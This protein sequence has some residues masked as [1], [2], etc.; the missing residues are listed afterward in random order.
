M[1]MAIIK[2]LLGLF[3][4]VGA[5]SFAPMQSTL[6]PPSTGLTVIELFTSQ[7]CSSCPPANDNLARLAG[8]PDVLALSFGV[9]YWDY[10]GWRDTFANRAYTQRQRDYARG[11]HRP[12]VY[13]PQM[14]INGRVD[15]VGNRM[16]DIDR[17]RGRTASI[18]GGPNV[19]LNGN[20]LE[21][22]TASTQGQ[23]ADIW[24]VR[25]DPRVIQVPIQRGEN[26]GKTLPHINV[27]RQFERVGSY[28]GQALRLSL[29]ASSQA[30]LRT[31]ILVQ[32]TGGG[33]ILAALKF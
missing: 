6:R 27:V 9:D 11:L 29:P 33:A 1:L 16:G 8:Q 24:L 23:M 26:S 22:G 28:N 7:G 13:T 3:A 14:V 18:I 21:I 32:T 12:N 2:T 5:A 4:L 20:Q 31:A 19:R 25:Y 10:L 30:N 15:L 17:A